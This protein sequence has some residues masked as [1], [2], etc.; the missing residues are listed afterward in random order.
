MTNT[1][2]TLIGVRVQEGAGR[3]GC[4]IG[5]DPWSWKTHTSRDCDIAVVQR[6]NGKRNGPRTIW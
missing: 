2:C 4:D 5:I 6:G 3:L 1:R